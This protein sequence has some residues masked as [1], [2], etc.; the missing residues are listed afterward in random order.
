MKLIPLLALTL[1]LASCATPNASAPVAE[2]PQAE[3]ERTPAANGDLTGDYLGEGLFSARKEGLERP[4]MRLYLNREAGEADTY[5]GVLFEY[6]NLLAM[7]VPYLAS[8]IAPDLNKVI[9]YL[10]EIG[11]R[12]EAFKLVPGPRVGTYNMHVLHVRGGKIVPAANPSLLLTLDPKQQG[13]VG[14]VITG[15]KDGNIVFPGDQ[16]AKSFGGKIIDLLSL[17][18]YEMAAL[19]YKKG[20]LASSWR[21]NWNDLEGSYLS[22]YGKLNDGVHELYTENGHRKVKFIKTKTTKAKHFTNPKSAPLVGEYLVSEPIP[23]MYVLTPTSKTRTAS[24]AELVGRIGLFL[25]VFDASA[26]Q[27]G[28]KMV[29]EL[30]YTNPNDAEDFLMYYEHPQHLKNV[31]VD[32]K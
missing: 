15:K 25:D 26:P 24:D 2:N 29:T 5:Y 22:Q 28:G 7:S 27:A 23:K 14:A 17:T 20:K 10:N 1:V 31:G 18:Q 6:T 12:I 19:A 4:A 8:D 11:T 32:G 21:G 13:L 9:G 30:V 3:S 16:K